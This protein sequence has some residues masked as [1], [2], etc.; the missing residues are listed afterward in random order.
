VPKFK[1]LD[2]NVTTPGRVP[3]GLPATSKVSTSLSEHLLCY[4]GSSTREVT[5]DIY[6]YLR[7]NCMS[8]LGCDKGQRMSTCHS[9]TRPCLPH[10]YDTYAT[11]MARYHDY[12]SQMCCRPRRL[13]AKYTRLI[14]RA[15]KTYG[16]RTGDVQRPSRRSSTCTTCKGYT[17]TTH[18][19]THA[20]IVT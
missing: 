6:T 8:K 3:K 7:Y 11:G 20:H 14:Q 17:H 18:T 10:C 1:K 13:H 16:R 5:T 4:I 12:V 15:T 19:H 9:T 2:T